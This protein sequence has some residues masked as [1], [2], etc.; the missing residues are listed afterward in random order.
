MTLHTTV[1]IMNHSAIPPPTMLDHMLPQSENPSSLTHQSE[2][3]QP[4]QTHSMTQHTGD[5]V[6]A[7]LTTHTAHH[8]TEAHTTTQDMLPTHHTDMELTGGEKYDSFTGAS[9]VTHA[10]QLLYHILM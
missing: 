8:T 5:H 9:H 1:D 4:L 2:L 10:V 3:S 7:I 6:T